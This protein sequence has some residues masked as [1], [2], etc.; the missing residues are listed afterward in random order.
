MILLCWTILVFNSIQFN[1]I[2]KRLGELEFEPHNIL[3]LTLDLKRLGDAW[4]LGF[5]LV[6]NILLHIKRQDI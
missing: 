5:M 1:S 4:G 3:P 2:Q 6:E